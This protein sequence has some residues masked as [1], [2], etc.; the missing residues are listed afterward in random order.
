MGKFAGGFKTDKAQLQFRFEAVEISE[1][2]PLGAKVTWRAYSSDHVVEFEKKSPDL[3]LTAI[4]KATGLEP[5]NV[6][7]T[8]SPSSE[9]APGRTVEGVY[10]LN[11]MPT[12]VDPN[13]AV[14]L[15]PAPLKDLCVETIIKCV[16]KV[17]TKLHHSKACVDE[18]NSW[19]AKI[20]PSDYDSR[21]YV[22]KLLHSGVKY[23]DPLRGTCF[24]QGNRREILTWKNGLTRHVLVD[25]NF[26]FP[27][28][29]AFA[30]NPIV[31]N[32]TPNPCRPRI[33]AVSSEDLVQ[34]FVFTLLST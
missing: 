31:T 10:F 3:C 5:I 24:Y 28:I 21:K 32:F 8:W 18:W 1:E 12:V 6:F 20:G 29:F 17:N 30:A 34:V 27:E 2:F 13:A 15:K 9:E 22:D 14:I 4:G 11:R 16:Q 25:A 33:Y 26:K 19:F 23:H 7:C